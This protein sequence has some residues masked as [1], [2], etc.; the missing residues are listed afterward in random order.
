MS[1]NIAKEYNEFVE[2]KKIF[3]KEIVKEVSMLEYTQFIKNK[4]ILE[5]YFLTIL[6]LNNFLRKLYLNEGINED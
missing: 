1:D 4:Y 6:I 2:I 5:S 3:Y